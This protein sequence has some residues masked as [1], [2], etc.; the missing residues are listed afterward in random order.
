MK[1]ISFFTENTQTAF[2]ILNTVI[3]IFPCFVNWKSVE[4]NYLEISIMGRLEDIA[5][6]EKIFSEI[7]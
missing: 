1:T 6:I 7:V 2:D 4:M 3:D 5:S